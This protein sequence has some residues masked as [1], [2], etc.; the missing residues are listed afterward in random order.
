MVHPVSLYIELVM[1]EEQSI[2]SNRRVF[3]G[4][5]GKILKWVTV[6]FALYCVLYIVGFFQYFGIFIFPR[7]HDAAFF[8]FIIALTFIYCPATKHAPRNRVPWY[9]VLAVILGIAVNV[10]IIAF[11]L[12]IS[13]R[14][15]QLPSLL[16]QAF[17]LITVILI[18]E[19]VRRTAGIAL[20][21]IG[22]LFFIYPFVAEWMPAFL[23]GRNQSLARMVEMMYVYPAGIYSTTLHL[24]AVLVVVFLI[25]GAFLTVSGAGNFLINLSYGLMGRYRGGPAK[26]AVLASS[27]FG[28]INGS[29]TANVAATG[30]I[31]IPLMKKLGYKP[32]YAAAVE[33]VASNGGQIMPPVLGLTAF[34]IMDFLGVSYL[35]VVIVSIIPALLYYV[36][37]FTMIHL[38]AVKTNIRGIPRENLPS[39]R[40]TLREGWPFLMPI[41][42]LVVLLALR[43]SAQTACL[44]SIGTLIIASWFKKDLRMGWRKISTALDEGM[45]VIPLIGVI[46][47]MAGI[48]I[49]VLNL[50]GFGL[51]MTGGLV[52]ISGGNMFLLLLMT[53]ICAMVLGMGMPGVAVYVLC[54]II[55]APSLVQAGIEPIVAHFFVFYY[56]ITSMLT[57]P[58]C[59]IAF[60]AAGI[61]GAPYMKTGWQAMRLGIVIFLIPFMFAYGSELMLMGAPNDIA[62]AVVTSFIGVVLL[63][64]GIEGYLTRMLNW[65]ERVLF[66]GAG[67]LMMIPSSMTDYAGIGIGVILVLWQYLPGKF[68]GLPSNRKAL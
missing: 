2:E 39:L 10:Y 52:A 62:I 13:S 5:G 30:V 32:Y 54:A 21:I 42:L 66:L 60:V 31:T 11:A 46:I 50:T 14:I 1:S 59:L 8:I 56:G 45:R 51:R 23:E 22:T 3:T 58:V 57:P 26:V 41:T 49:G 16:E 43:F 35:E 18:I 48:L 7:R 9:D 12:D 4:T 61:A 67:I 37:L 6:A 36:A 63:S 25:F 24:I 19:G 27:L 65:L 28:S 34:L 55:L 40:K 53:A 29:G 44:Y 20:S 38:E 64:A 17:G 68:R 33:A 15:Y 47:C